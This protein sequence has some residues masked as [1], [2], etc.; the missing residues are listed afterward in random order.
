MWHLSTGHTLKEDTETI[1]LLLN[2]EMEM[3]ICK[4]VFTIT[5]FFQS[6]PEKMESNVEQKPISSMN[7]RSRDV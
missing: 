4:D 7:V 2:I 1:H 5:Y 3:W 6:K